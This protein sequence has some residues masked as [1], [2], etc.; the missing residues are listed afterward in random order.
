MTKNQLTHVVKSVIPDSSIDID[1]WQSVLDRHEVTP[2]I[3]HL[4]NTV[5]YYVSYFSQNKSVNLSLVLYNNKQPVGVMPL[6]VH[7]NELNE[8]ILSSNGVEIVEP[9]FIPTLARKVK[10][11]LESQLAELIN[12]LSNKLYIRYCQ[13]TNMEYGQLSSWYLMW[14]ERASKTFS[15]HHLL[16]D[17]SLSLEEIRLK[18]R[19]S[20]KPLINKAL[21]EWRI[22][23]H[24]SVSEEIFD[25]FRLLHKEV[26]GQSTRPI[27]SWN[28]QKKQIDLSESFLIT[29]SNAQNQM[30]GAGL[31]TY[32]NYH[33]LY[34][35]GVYKRELF[36]KPLGHAVQ[37]KAIEIL[38]NKGLH[39]YEIG[40]KHLKVDRNPATDKELS[41]SH[42]KEGFS[43]Q[44]VARQHLIVDIQLDA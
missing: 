5:Q 26:A 38:K 28:E 16:V 34:C 41:I 4:L 12:T 23:T 7:K 11:R 8:W 22:E 32:S 39:W 27:E 31:F 6:M 30:V 1:A 42:F 40:Q 3:F 24:E 20:F 43:T 18:F 35:V 17:L 9:I 25:Q 29:V 33:S 19:K 44:V 13:F 10:K 15:T 14:I 36:D 2:S 37:M 21:R